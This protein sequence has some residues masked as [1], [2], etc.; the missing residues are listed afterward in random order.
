MVK[1]SYP[2]PRQLRGR[3]ARRTK[4]EWKTRRH[5]AAY[6]RQWRKL[7]IGIDAETPAIQV[8]E[9]TTNA[10]GDALVFPDLLA[11]ILEGEQISRVGA[12]GAYETK[13]SH[14]AIAARGV[15]VVIPVCCDGRPWEE[16]G[17]GAAARY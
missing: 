3:H 5:G 13:K 17:P 15:H 14:A 4:G 10:I 2:W 11:Q 16:D 12:V 1:R 6:R 9:V 7:Q 8:I